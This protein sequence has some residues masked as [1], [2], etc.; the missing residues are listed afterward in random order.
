MADVSDSERH[1]FEQVDI[2]D[3]REVE[4]LFHQYC[5]DIVMHLAAESHIDR[6]IDSPD[7]FISTNITGTYI[8]L[9]AARRFWLALDRGKKE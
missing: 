9:E 8:M 4:R 7:D 1:Q 2:C 3:S 5:P 6:S